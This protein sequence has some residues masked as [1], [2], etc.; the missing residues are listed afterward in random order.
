VHDPQT[1]TA[2]VL[3]LILIYLRVLRFDQ[4]RRYRP[5]PLLGHHLPR[6]GMLSSQ[7]LRTSHSAAVWH[8]ALAHAVAAATINVMRVG[9]NPATWAETVERTAA[10]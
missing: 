8:S 6:Q 3:A 1:P 4:Q 9:C 5:H 7:A 10:A 2:R